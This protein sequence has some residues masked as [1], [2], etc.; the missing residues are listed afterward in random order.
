MRQ[1]YHQLSL[2]LC[3]KLSLV[4]I[5]SQYAHCSVVVRFFQLGKD[6]FEEEESW[7]Q[8]VNAKQRKDSF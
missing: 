7:L 4:K 8:A 6:G 2:V 1:H 5:L 3:P